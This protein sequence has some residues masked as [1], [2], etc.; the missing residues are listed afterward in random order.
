MTTD[1][2][3]Q[4]G[5]LH[6]YPLVSFSI[7]ALA[8]GTGTV[9]LVVQGILPANVALASSLSAS[10]AGIIMIAVEDGRAGLNKMLKQLLIWRVGIGYWLFALLFLVPAILLGS[11]ANPLFNGDPLSISKMDLALEILPMFIIF[12]IVAGLGQELGWTGYLIPRLQ[13]RFN[14]LTSCVIRAFLGG[15]WHLPLLFYSRYQHPAL[16]DFPYGGWIAE[17]GFLVTVGALTLMFLLPWSILSS[18]IFNNTRGSLLLVAVLH[19]SEIWVAFWMLSAGI[20]PNNIN[21]Y[22]GYGTVMVM[23]A[24]I[25]VITTGW[26]NLSRKY[27]RIV[28]PL[29]LG[30]DM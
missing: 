5:F 22:W 6:R 17:K 3:K 12:F 23:I 14:A 26:Q 7:L 10:I 11:I 18:W 15:L 28:H 27:K 24:T 2:N 21:N 4:F 20:N 30:K 25:I 29:L 8:L 1:T 19:G 16:A 13:A 9:T